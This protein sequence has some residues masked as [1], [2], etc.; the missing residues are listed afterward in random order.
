M[1]KANIVYLDDEENKRVLGVD[2]YRAN[3]FEHAA[4]WRRLVRLGRLRDGGRDGGRHSGCGERDQDLPVRGLKVEE[5]ERCC[6]SSICGER[7]I[8]L[9]LSDSRRASI[10]APRRKV[11]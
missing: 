2:L 4:L 10:Q 3:A 6:Q 8:R 1:L 5:G 9:Y 11:G 7:R